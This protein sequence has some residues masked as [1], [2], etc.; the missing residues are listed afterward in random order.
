MTQVIDT[1]RE[2]D[3]A[4]SP[5]ILVFPGDER[6]DE[7]RRAWNLAVDQRPA[8]VARPET[9]EDVQAVVAHA[10][11]LGLEVAV[12]G[13]GHGASA[14]GDLAGAVLVDMFRLRGVE[15]DPEARV[16]R[17]LAGTIWQ[18]VVDAAVP[19]G[20]TALHGSAHDVGVVGYT[21]GGGVGWLARKHGLSSS[22]VVAVELVTAVGDHVRADAE[23]ETDLF[24]AVRGGGGS[25]GVVTAVEIELIPLTEVFAGWLAWP[26][27]RADEVLSAWA[28][29]TETV[30][31][32]MTSLGRLLQ[33]PPIPEIPEPL[34]GRQLVVVEAA[35]LG[36]EASGREL[37][38]PLL[39]LG[40]ELDTFAVVPAEALTSLHQ[41]P[42]Q[43]APGVGHGWTLAGFDA[44]AASALVAAA[45]MDGTS[46]LLSVEVRHAGGALGRP[47]PRGGALSHLADPYVLFAIG[48][49]MGPVTP[50]AIDA[51]LDALAE[52]LAPWASGRSYLNFAERRTDTRAFF[53]AATHERL[54]AIR[55]AVDPD[56]LLRANHPI[57]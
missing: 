31:D 3:V 51:R 17:V 18:E 27:D 13:T 33:L 34:R 20:L 2:L 4:V 32:E 42:P 22:K 44:A 52:V 49:P 35:Y 28:A 10:R 37:L 41:D 9:V 16:A 29:W 45:G 57:G 12:Q 24:W 53:P 55:R 8:V 25:F 1:R 40:P 54:V 47:D 21:L 26:V 19:H 56:G 7:A 43:P 6:Y 48:I 46:P 30:P 39:E 15:V 36:D 11:L 5:R 38:Q 23:N 50:V 14:R